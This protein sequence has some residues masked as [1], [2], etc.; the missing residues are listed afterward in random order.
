MQTEIQ[1]TVN[2]A[3]VIINKI[4]KEEL[5]YVSCKYLCFS[6]SLKSYQVFTHLIFRRPFPETERKLQHARHV[7]IVGETAGAEAPP[8]RPCSLT[9]PYWAL[10]TIHSQNGT[11]SHPAWSLPATCHC[12]CPSHVKLAVSTGT[13]ALLSSHL[14][15]WPK[16]Q[17][18]DGWCRHESVTRERNTGGNRE[19]TMARQVGTWW[20][21]RPG[22]TLPHG[23]STFLTSFGSKSLIPSFGKQQSGTQQC[24]SP[25]ALCVTL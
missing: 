10:I 21:I 16:S 6:L 4:I 24:Q 8:G 25:Q 7:W 2:R 13:R 22:S 14:G 18:T 17:T 15:T 23:L 9:A 19:R 12:S 11:T 3:A 20:V 5:Y 1:Q